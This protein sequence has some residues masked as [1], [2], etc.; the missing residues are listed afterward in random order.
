[1]PQFVRRLRAGAA[2]DCYHTLVAVTTD[3]EPLGLAVLKGAGRDAEVEQ[4]FLA[5][6]A[7]GTGLAANLMAA[8]VSKLRG[9]VSA[10]CLGPT[11]PC[12]DWQAFRCCAHS[13]QM[14][15]RSS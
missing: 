3:G 10:S 1:M 15:L 6:S 13:W 11:Q 4:F 2:A 7:R 14:W 8:A 12:V 9:M 5:K